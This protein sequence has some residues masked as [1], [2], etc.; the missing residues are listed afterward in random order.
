MHEITMICWHWNTDKQN[1]ETLEGKTDKGEHNKQ[2]NQWQDDD[3]EH[4]KQNQTEACAA[5]AMGT[6]M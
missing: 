1:T 4:S 2:T 5:V 3:E 6:S